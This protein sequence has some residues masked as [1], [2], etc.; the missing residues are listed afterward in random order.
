MSASPHVGVLSRYGVIFLAE[1][2]LLRTFR[3]TT[4]AHV[5]TR[6][7]L[8]GCSRWICKE[9]VQSFTPACLPPTL[10]ATTSS[11]SL[12]FTQHRDQTVLRGR[13]KPNPKCY[14]PR[15]ATGRLLNKEPLFSF[16]FDS[17]FLCL[18]RAVFFFLRFEKTWLRLECF[19]KNLGSFSFFLSLFPSFFCQALRVSGSGNWFWMPN[20]VILIKGCHRYII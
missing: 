9:V 7:K 8:I 10:N 20:W 17:H 1:R 4:K 6:F 18:R 11:S 3:Q 15:E 13:H 2:S 5:S 12:L 16:R 14:L 19:N